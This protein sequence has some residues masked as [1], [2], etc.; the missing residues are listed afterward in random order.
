MP[1]CER[2]QPI[3]RF[4]RKETKNIRS[5]SP[6]CAIEKIDTRGFPPAPWSILPM[7]S[8]S[9]SSHASKPGEARR[10]LSVI[11]RV[12]RSFSGKNAS[13][14]RTPIRA[15][16]GDWICPM[17]AGRS[18]SR[19]SFQA[20][21]RSVETRMCSRLRSGSASIPSRPSSPV[22]VAV[23]CSVS[24]SPS[25]ITAGGGAARDFR[26]ET[27]SPALLPGV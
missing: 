10:M 13:S 8:G 9:P 24:A 17:R 1:D 23:I 27:G 7:S 16:G 11:A 26:T 22:T 25:S 2:I 6:R 5:A 4:R 12:K 21:P 19:P 18:R 3:I 14:S 15:T 20:A